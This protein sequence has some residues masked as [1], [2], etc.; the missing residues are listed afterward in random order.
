M[1]FKDYWFVISKR[2]WV[3]LLLMALTSGG[4][5]IYSK[6][7]QPI[8]RSTAK[9]YVTPARPDYGVTLVI[10]NLIRQYSQLLESDKFLSKVNDSL[11]LD[12]TPAKLRSKIS[13]S[14]T[15]D[16]LAIQVEVDDPNPLVAQRIARGLA[17]EFL[18]NHQRRMALVDQRDK[19][20]V[21]MYDDPEPGVLYSPKT[22]VN[23]LAAAILGL[24]LGGVVSFALEYLDDTIKSGADVERYVALPV[25]GSIPTMSF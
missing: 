25:V 14:G 18:E 5:Y 17:L 19:I 11:R 7:Q 4:A 2:W 8:Y 3:F 9:L 24:L 13:A 23:V 1:Q 20:D 16:N 12:L 15:A 22:R 10:Q 21:E 6:A